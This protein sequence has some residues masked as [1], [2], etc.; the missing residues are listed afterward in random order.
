MWLKYIGSIYDEYFMRYSNILRKEGIGGEDCINETILCCYESIKRN[1]LKDLSGQGMRNYWF[2]SLMTNC[3]IVDNYD[4]RKDGG[5][6]PS[7]ILYEPPS[8]KVSLDMRKDF[9]V[10]YLMDKAEEKFDTITFSCFRLK[11]LVPGMTYSRLREVTKVK[12]AKK[13]TL[14]VMHW[15]KDNVSEKEIDEAFEKYVC[16]EK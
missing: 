15:L 10:I 16:G 3:N 6:I 2:R 11:H 12:D 8:N 1:G 7:D 4:K 14:E 9:S 13:R 5:S